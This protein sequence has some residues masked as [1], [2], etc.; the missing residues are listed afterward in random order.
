MVAQKI[1][2]EQTE[3]EEW[4]SLSIS[5]LNDLFEPLTA[6]QRISLLKKY[7][8]QEDILMTSSFG[9]KSVVLLHL[10]NQ[11]FPT[12]PI[13]FLDTTYHFEETIEYKRKLTE[14]MGLNIIDLMPNQEE[15]QL[16]REQ[17]WWKDHP[18]MCCT[19]NK[20]APLEPI[21]ARHKIWVS[22]VM[23]YQTKF[24]SHLRVFEKQGEILKFHPLIDSTEEEFI[25]F[26]EQYELP[27]HPLEGQGYGSVGCSHCTVK[28]EGRSGRWKGSNKAE[29]GLHPGYFE[30]KLKA[31]RAQEA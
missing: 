3:L 16:T 4:K 10:F 5:L 2:S 15:N 27:R 17:K 6:I 21:K 11:E 19:I 12:H 14:W 26:F 29:C 20:V 9:T 22:G 30:K 18:N 1:K 25:A 23:K 13:Y 7:F 8:Q 24:R 31:K 28:G